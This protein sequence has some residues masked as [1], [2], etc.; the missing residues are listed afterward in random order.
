M[1]LKGCLGLQGAAFPFSP[2]GLRETR[3]LGVNPK[4]AALWGRGRNGFPRGGQTRKPH[5]TCRAR[6]GGEGQKQEPGGMTDG[7][8][9]GPG[10]PAGER[11]RDPTPVTLGAGSSQAGSGAWPTWP[12]TPTSA[13]EQLPPRPPPPGVRRLYVPYLVRLVQ[14]LLPVVQLLVQVALLFTEQLLEHRRNRVWASSIRPGDA[15]LRAAW[16]DVHQPSRSPGLP[17][18]AAGPAPSLRS[19]GATGHGQKVQG[20]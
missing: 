12:P 5:P 6:L 8:S 16:L 19:A 20:P 13:C 10:S 14:G 3:T 17:S 7:N 11:P 4:R 18:S 2:A 1:K 9:P 15:G